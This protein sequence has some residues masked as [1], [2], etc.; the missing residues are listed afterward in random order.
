LLEVIPR[1]AGSEFVLAIDIRFA[2]D[3]AIL[4][5]FEAFGCE[6]CHVTEA[7]CNYQKY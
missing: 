1:Y 7:R 4:G 2:S 6:L 3:T 5:E